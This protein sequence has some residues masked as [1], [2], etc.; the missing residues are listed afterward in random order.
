M[1]CHKICIHIYIYMYMHECKMICTYLLYVFMYV[2]TFYIQ[3]QY[4]MDNRYN[5]M[6]GT[7]TG[8]YADTFTFCSG[9]MHNRY[10]SYQDRT[11]IPF[12]KSLFQGTYQTYSNLALD[13]KRQMAPS[14][15]MQEN[16]CS[17]PHYHFARICFDL[18]N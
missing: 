7:S 13:L 5:I 17:Y 18:A 2:H 9:N 15:T 12:T 10:F 8:A 3:V 4:H 6:V 1:Y 11:P 14:R 16:R